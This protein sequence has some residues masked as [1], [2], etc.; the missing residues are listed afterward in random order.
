MFVEMDNRNLQCTTAL[1][2]PSSIPILADQETLRMRIESS[3]K[4][5]AQSSDGLHSGTRQQARDRRAEMCRLPELVG[6]CVC[7]CGRRGRKSF[8]L[9]CKASRHTKVVA[10]GLPD[11]A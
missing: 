10:T 11:G 1:A 9:S 3:A 6:G 5:Q 4:L 7:V 8:K 2:K